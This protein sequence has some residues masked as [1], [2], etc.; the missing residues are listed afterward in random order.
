MVF[1]NIFIDLLVLGK[2]KMSVAKCLE[3]VGYVPAGPEVVLPVCH[4]SSTCFGV[5]ALPPMPV[6]TRLCPLFSVGAG[7]QVQ[8]R[9]CPHPAHNLG[10]HPKSSEEDIM[11]EIITQY[12]DFSLL[13]V[14]LRRVMVFPFASQG[15]TLVSS[16]PWRNDRH[17]TSV[18]LWT[19]R[20]WHHRAHCETQAHK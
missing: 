3:G 20:S 10:G 15:V 17:L 6:W 14:F 7:S 12:G 2:I 1:I 18:H 19:S 16:T 9:T 11:T 5:P 4:V 8:S 13:L